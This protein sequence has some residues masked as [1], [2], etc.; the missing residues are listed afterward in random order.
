MITMNHLMFEV[1]MKSQISFNG[2]VASKI[3]EF[4]NKVFPEIQLIDNNV[5]LLDSDHI[6]RGNGLN[7][8][9]IYSKFT[10]LT[11][12][13]GSCNEIRLSD[14]ID[15]DG[16]SLV[17]ITLKL[18]ERLQ[19]YLK[20]TFPERKFRIFAK[21]DGDETEIRFHIMRENEPNWLLEDLE[22]Y[23]EALITFDC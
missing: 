21:I 6:F 8:D 2:I 20:T 11:G 1:L 4:S 7:Y 14:Y 19:S 16:T 9:F 18:S 10:D 13:E 5:I 12:Y 22:G 15:L 17:T 3:E 23:Q